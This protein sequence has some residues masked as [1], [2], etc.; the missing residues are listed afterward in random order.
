M[1]K[2]AWQL[3]FLTVGAAVF[4]L[5][6]CDVDQVDEGEL[7]E[8]EVEEGELPEY[9]VDAPEVDVRSDTDTVIVETPEVDVDLPEDS[10]E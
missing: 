6:A 9:E 2:F 4:L 1:M 7:P 10:E 3:Q 5:G 8:V